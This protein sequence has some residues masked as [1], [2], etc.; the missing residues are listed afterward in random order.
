V[1][2]YVARAALVGLLL[3]AACGIKALPQPPLLAAALAPDGGAVRFPD[4][5]CFEC[6]AGAR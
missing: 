6:P 2:A 1:N 4:G 5:G 3:A